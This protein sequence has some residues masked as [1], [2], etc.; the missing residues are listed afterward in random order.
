MN[1]PENREQSLKRLFADAIF[2]ATRASWQ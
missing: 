1:A 2:G